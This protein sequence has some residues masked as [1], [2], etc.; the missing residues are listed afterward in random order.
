[1]TEHFLPHPIATEFACGADAV[2]RRNPRVQCDP[3]NTTCPAC[4]NTPAH[5]MAI[6]PDAPEVEL[7]QW[8]TPKSDIDPDEYCQD[9]ERDTREGHYGF[10][11]AQARHIAALEG[12]T[13]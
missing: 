8:G 5:A 9:C 2:G 10:C 12:V 13:P 1:M 3:N 4:L 6:D 7:S 11:I